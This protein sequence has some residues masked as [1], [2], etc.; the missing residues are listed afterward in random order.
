MLINLIPSLP[1]AVPIYINQLNSLPS[2]LELNNSISI[3]NELVDYFNTKV[4]GAI[5]M[6][7]RFTYSFTISEALD[8]YGY[9][10]TGNSSFYSSFP[11]F[12]SSSS[13]ANNC[14]LVFDPLQ[15]FTIPL[16]GINYFNFSILSKNNYSCILDVYA[17]SSPL[18]TTLPPDSLFFTLLGC[19]HGQV[20][21]SS[22]SSLYDFCSGIFSF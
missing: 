19:P 13:D 18:I 5:Y 17:T 12:S 2:G 11:S 22:S 3:H 1:P 8:G 7:N 9:G 20:V 21:N 6:N 14:I 16:N 15:N 4:E 10:G